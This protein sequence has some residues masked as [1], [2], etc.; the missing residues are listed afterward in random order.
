VQHAKRWGRILP[1]SFYARPTIEVARALLGQ[2]LV[3]GPTAGIIVETEAYLGGDDLASHSA[4]GLT[5]RTRVIFGPPGHAY[6]YFI[7]GM[8][9]CLN[10]VAEAPGQPGCV[11]IRA[12]EPVA[13]LDLMHRRR[14]AARKPEQ[15]ANGPGKLTLAMAITRV[16]NGADVTRGSLVVRASKDSTAFEIAVTPRIGISKC[17][18]LPLRFLIAGN[19]YVSPTPKTR[20]PVNMKGHV[21]LDAG[22]PSPLQSPDA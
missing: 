11:L 19:R 6:V 9:E 15:L 17:A 3:H 22:S 16:Q 2:V 21:R 13:G 10:L 18:D 5:D 4:A 8:Y 20:P 7:Y 1:R 14:P 12:L